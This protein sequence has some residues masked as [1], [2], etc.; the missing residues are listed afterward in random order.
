MNRYDNVYDAPSSPFTKY[1]QCVSI[2]TWNAY[3]PHIREPI[4]KIPTKEDGKL[5]TSFY[6]Y[7]QNV[8]TGQKVLTAVLRFH[9]MIM[10]D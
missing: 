9:H 8:F 5:D 1:E 6:A 2:S 7:G 3:V 4:G 10:L